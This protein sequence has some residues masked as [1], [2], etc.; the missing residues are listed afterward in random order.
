M[1]EREK[2]AEPTTQP[3]STTVVQQREA[4]WDRDTEESSEVIVNRVCEGLPSIRSKKDRYHVLGL[5]R[6]YYQERLRIYIYSA[7]LRFAGEERDRAM[8]APDEADF[9]YWCRVGIYQRVVDKLRMLQLSMLGY[10]EHLLAF[11]EMEEQEAYR[12]RVAQRKKLTSP[13]GPRRAPDPTLQEAFVY[14]GD[15]GMILKLLEREGYINIAGHWYQSEKGYKAQLIAL[16]R[17]LVEK[18]YLKPL[19]Q[20]TLARVM[21]TYF[22]VPLSRSYSTRSVD[23]S[24][25]EAFAKLIPNQRGVKA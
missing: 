4:I 19:P 15:Y 22:K 6:E 13:N 14:K 24:L 2:E 8:K 21:A 11:S 7:G 23:N 3:V 9:H 5:T 16:M 1:I 12:L 17:V 18:H 20:A 10:H 25:V